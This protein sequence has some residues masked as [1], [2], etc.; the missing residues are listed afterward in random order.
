MGPIQKFIENINKAFESEE[1]IGVYYANPDG[2]QENNY[3]G[4]N[5]DEEF[6]AHLPDGT[7]MGKCTNCAH[8][9]VATLG[10]GEVYGFDTRENPVPNSAIMA[11]M[12][13]DFAVLRDRFIVDIWT[14]VYAGEE[15]QIVYDLHNKKDFAKISEIYGSPEKWKYCDPITKRFQDNIDTPGEKILHLGRPGTHLGISMSI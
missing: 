2:I 3:T 14:T 5:P 4:N 13:H 8:Y 15:T 10:E 6:W 12:G 7:Q 9:V 11:A 1:K